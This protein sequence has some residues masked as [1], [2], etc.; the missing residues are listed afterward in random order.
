MIIYEVRG[1]E[2]GKERKGGN[3]EEDKGGKAGGRW[4]MREG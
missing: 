4:K 3:E 1:L 2:R